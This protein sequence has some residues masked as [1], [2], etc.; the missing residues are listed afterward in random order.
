MDAESDR[1]RPIVFGVGA[2]VGLVGLMALMG[3]VGSP[4][5]S[6]RFEV[7]SPIQGVAALVDASAPETD[8]FNGQFCGGVVV[9]DRRILTAAHCMANR[10][11]AGTD[12]IVGADN[13]CRERAIDGVRA[14]VIAVRKDERWDPASARYDLAWLTVDRDVGPGVPAATPT[15]GSGDATAL[16]WG[17]PQAMANAPCRLAATTVR[18]REQDLCPSL[19]GSSERAFDPSSMLCAVPT[20]PYEDT[21]GGDSGGPL[22]LGQLPTLEGLAGIVSWGRGCGQGF[23]GVY[24]RLAD[25]PPPDSLNE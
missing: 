20:A 13:L 5:P 1:P 22:F 17:A 23:A 4:A 7:G 2:A 24:A 14:H 3:V 6:G 12:V 11:G 9:A 25:E 10:T 18:I 21:C 8:P 19:V 16:G 15:A